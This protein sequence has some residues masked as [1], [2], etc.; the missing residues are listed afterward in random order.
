MEHCPSMQIHNEMGGLMRSRALKSPTLEAHFQ[1]ICTS[2]LHFFQHS[3]SK[4]ELKIVSCSFPIR[5]NSFMNLGIKNVILRRQDYLLVFF[6]SFTLGC[7]E[8]RIRAAERRPVSKT[9]KTRMELL[10]TQ[11][12]RESSSRMH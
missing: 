12:N 1:N 2:F 9:W 6:T 3:I 10:H 5:Q 11:H 4:C 7:D 8:M